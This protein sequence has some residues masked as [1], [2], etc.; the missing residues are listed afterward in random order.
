VLPCAHRYSIVT[1]MEFRI[2]GPLE[3]V[4]EGQLVALPGSRERTV[5]A[6]LLLSA[7]Q[8]V[9]SERLID[10][11]WGDRAR[12][13][14]ADALRVFV[15]RLRKALK[16]GG[17]DATIVF[18][19]P[20]YLLEIDRANL[21][22]ARFDA[23]VTRGSDEATQ[24]SHA[25]AAA[26]LSEAL[27]L[28]RGPALSDV[29]D[30]LTIR[31]EAARLE[32]ARLGATEDRIEADLACGRHGPL[33]P[34][35]DHLASAHPFRERLWGQRMV[36]LY[37]CGR[38]ADALRAYQDLRRLLADELGLDPSPDVAALESAIL[39]HDP[40]LNAR[41]PARG[42]TVG[43]VPPDR[44]TTFL[45]SDI[46]ASTR[47]WEGD[48]ERMAADLA[49]H[50][51]LLRGA[52][53]LAGGSIFAHTGD[54]MGA[55]FTDA[56]N[57][58]EAAV[59]AQR[60]LAEASW[61]AG[62][63]RVRM[64]IHAGSAERR[65]DNFFGPALNRVARLM[66]CAA[67]GQVLCSE[68]AAEL[69][70]ADLPAGVGLV[71]LGEHRLA[72]LA[73][74]ERILQ[75]VHAELPSDF[76][77]LRTVGG[78]RHNLPVALTSFIGRDREL[79]ELGRL[80]GTARLLTLTG[81]G[82]A[83]KTRLGLETATGALDDYP[84]GVWMIEL[85]PVREAT[86]VPAALAAA[87]S[88]ETSVSDTP[89]VLA[90]RLVRH[91]ATRRTLLLFDNC[92]HLIEPV[93][94]LV[95][96]ILTHCPSVTVLSTSRELL[97]VAGEVACRVPPLSLPAVEADVEE[98]A[99]SDAVT[100]FCER[101]R[102]TRP[103]FD[104]TPDNAFAVARICRRLDGIPLALE[105]AAARV[106]VLN[107]AQVADRLDGRF[108][109]LT[110]RDRI[111]V[112]R[113]HTLRT[114][115]DWSY[116][117]LSASERQALARLSVF[118]DTFDLDAAG[119]VIADASDDSLETMTRL[120][121]K[122]L[123]VVHTQD[124]V[125]RYRLLETIREYGAEKLAAVG[126]E[127]ATGRRHCA[128]FVARVRRWRGGP[129]G[130][131]WL[132]DTFSDTGNFRTALEWSWAAGDLE[133]TLWLYSGLW[134]WW[135]WVGNAEG[136]QWADRIV[137]H[138]RFSVREL[139]DHPGRVGVFVLKALLSA[140]TREICEAMLDEGKAIAE[141]LVD[142]RWSAYVDFVRGEFALAMGDGAS[143]RALFQSGLAVAERLKM[144][145]FAG[146]CHEHLGWTA[147]D[148]GD[149]DR[150][151]AHFEQAAIWARSDP[152]GEWLEPHALAA[153]APLVARA[154][155][156]LEATRLAEEAINAARRLPARP[157]LAM[158]LARAADAAIVAGQP[159]RA[160][161][162]LIQVL[163]VIA[164]LGTRRYLADALELSA[165]VMVD[166]G[167]ETLHTAGEVLGAA[168]ALR[169]DAGEPSRSLMISTPEVHRTRGRLSRAL[170]PDRLSRFEANGGALAVEAMICRA[171]AG[172]RASSH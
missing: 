142:E 42:A 66:A 73:R 124:P 127:A 139:A 85:A 130:A 164:D 132:N 89:D 170:G 93:A 129:L 20:G 114:M 64:A 169:D 47:R 162:I 50:D 17:A 140:P 83:G 82:G 19:P 44:P 46:E 69:V 23:L 29:G 136:P 172:L 49:R 24:G 104:L 52:V 115:V 13:R 45:F 150:G 112:P 2:L 122:S 103:A 125:P 79:E 165:V 102:A 61:E 63:L 105:L 108:K 26:T 36:A 41:R 60:A 12:E 7:N 128:H 35:L 126:E 117:L 68:A 6:L 166:D 1:S 18:R 78:H 8:V 147:L 53:E 144:S 27:A 123:V 21:D 76:P 74:P 33:V 67:G 3:V 156:H 39:R 161:S 77:P 54:G 88:F 10:E 16:D 106:G 121:D 141:R 59:C 135:F 133:S 37:R 98:L 148:E 160:A 56:A 155:D 152:V 100:F 120:V 159:R 92:E 167:G 22:A 86:D 116:E 25:A 146:W 9:S 11:L 138:P 113:H 145:D 32:E 157:L 5:F 55:A 91:L 163:G 51:A 94:R 171:L 111:T 158:A 99:R 28:W 43:A 65:D 96:Q 149:L 84:D 34:E 80:L 4:S 30:T 110:G 75:L 168:R 131:D 151:R 71:D 58:F 97:G 57:A 38:Q 14:A 90:A 70:G 107:P 118:P 143:A 109:L 137:A 15:S 72:D 48:P 87:L 81:V 31:A 40:G 153:L 62:P 101:A 119:A 134:I 154:G 95:H